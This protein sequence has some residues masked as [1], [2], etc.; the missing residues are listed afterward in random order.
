MSL[1][2]KDVPAFMT[3]AGNPAWAVGL[4]V[5]G[6]KRRNISAA[7]R[8]A[9]KQAHRLVYRSGLTAAALSEMADLRAELP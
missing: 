3:V 5:E 8:T 2:T 7:A 6:M 1:V 9:V 4:N